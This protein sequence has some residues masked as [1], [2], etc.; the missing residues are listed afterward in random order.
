MDLIKREQMADLMLEYEKE[1]QDKYELP[2]STHNDERNYKIFRQITQNII[3]N[4]YEE[5]L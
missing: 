2:N 4:N 3:D 1:L 5:I